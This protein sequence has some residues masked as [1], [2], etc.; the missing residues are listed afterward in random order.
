MSAAF[1]DSDFCE[2][3]GGTPDECS[4]SWEERYCVDRIEAG[5]AT[6]PGYYVERC[7]KHEGRA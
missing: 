3:C 7:V 4:C 5:E 6:G 1:E 2:C